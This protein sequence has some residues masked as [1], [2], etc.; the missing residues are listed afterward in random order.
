MA[1]RPTSAATLAD[2]AAASGVSEIT[3]SRV[4]RNRGPVAEK[5]RARVLIS[6]ERLGYVPNPIAGAMASAESS[7]V[8]VILPSLSNSVFPEV[9]AGINAG[10]EG[11]G[12][13]PVIGVTD[14][15]REVEERLVRS[16]L[17][18][19]PAAV[20]LGGGGHTEGTRRLLARSPVRVAELMDSD[21]APIDLAIGLSHR[22][23]GREIARHLLARGYRRF[24]Y[25]GHDWAGDERARFRYLGLEQELLA[26]GLD[27]VGSRLAPGPSSAMAGR[28]ALGALLASGAAPDVVVFSNDDMAIGGVMHCLAAGLVPKR[29]L[30]IFGF[31]GLEVG[32]CLPQPLS[33]VRSNRFEVGRRA[34]RRLLESRMRG[35]PEVIDTGFELLAGETA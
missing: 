3:V 6:V 16:V 7:L 31:N 12:L 32:Q 4:L 10:L 8:G 9:L 30:G 34:M 25:V 5:T 24:G 33:T 11:S 17:A 19:R 20:L 2:V 29:D 14:Y 27:V 35:E 26:A 15:D 13:T 28:E 23:A 1:R 22:G 21:V 18:W